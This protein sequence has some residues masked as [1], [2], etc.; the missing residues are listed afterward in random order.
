MLFVAIA[1]DFEGDEDA[2]MMNDEEFAGSGIRPSL[3][4]RKTIEILSQSYC[5]F[6]YKNFRLYWNSFRS[7]FTNITLS[8]T[9]R[10]LE[11]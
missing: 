4:V 7:I 2:Y 8:V 5:S 1:D 3:I 9:K 10:E 6:F 11:Y